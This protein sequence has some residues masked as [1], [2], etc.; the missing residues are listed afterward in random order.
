MAVSLILVP[1]LVLHLVFLSRRYKV[2]CFLLNFQ[3]D[4]WI[5]FICIRQIILIWFA[6]FLAVYRDG[7]TWARVAS[8]CIEGRDARNLRFLI[9]GIY[10]NVVPI[11]LDVVA[12]FL[13]AIVFLDHQSGIFILKHL[14]LK[15]WKYLFCSIL[16]L[17]YTLIHDVSFCFCLFQ[18]MFDR[19]N[20]SEC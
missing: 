15:L 19:S 17:K 20:T 13:N 12:N 16:F 11:C 18:C 9:I 2:L 5:M 14:V 6:S 1:I 3:N 7:F 4:F 8:W 10:T